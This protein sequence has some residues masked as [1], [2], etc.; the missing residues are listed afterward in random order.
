MFVVSYVVIVAFHPHLKLDK[1]IVNRS[2]GHDLEQLASINYFSREQI[3]FAEQYL[4]NMMR[5]YAKLVAKRNCKNSLGEM[6]SV[7]IA[8]IK[9]TLLKWFN[10]KYQRNFLV[11]NPIKKVKYEINHKVDMHKSKCSICKFPLKLN[12]TEYNNTEMTYGD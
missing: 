4:L 9:K 10:I 11:V 8:L 5:E 7:E 2:F 12:I 3:S 6:F 1:I